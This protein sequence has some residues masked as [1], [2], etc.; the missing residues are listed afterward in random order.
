MLALVPLVGAVYAQLIVAGFFVLVM[1]AALLWQQFARPRAK[2][3]K[4]APM[5]FGAQDNP[6]RQTQ[7]AQIAMIVEA[8]MLG[9]SLS[10]R[11]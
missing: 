4:A 10:R 5:A 2:P 6:Q 7:F 9:Y 8:V 11:R 1:A 3:A